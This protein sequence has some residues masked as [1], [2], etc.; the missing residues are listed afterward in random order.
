M[1][2]ASQIGKRIR[3]LRLEMGL[4]QEELANKIGVDRV[5]VTAYENG[6]R[7][8]K[9]DTK[10]KLSILFDTKVDDLFFKV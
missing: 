3:K 5:T 9:D 6:L 1:P 8:P 10:Q 2:N 7:I 4:T